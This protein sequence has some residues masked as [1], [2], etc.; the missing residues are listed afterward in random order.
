MARLSALGTRKF[1][2]W[3]RGIEQRRKELRLLSRALPALNELLSAPRQRLDACAARLP[4]ALIANAQLHH[5]QLDRATSRLSKRLLTQRT[6]RC[7]EQTAVFGA[8][9]SRAMLTLLDQRGARLE[10]ADRLLEAFSYR[11]VL[12][13][14]FALV[15]DGEGHPLRRASAVAS[16]ASLDI[17]FADGRV[18]AVAAGEARM[19]P[20][21][22]PRPRRRGGADNEGQGSLFGS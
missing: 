4:R 20:A 3:Q 14:G 19:R 5:R 8:R 1:S 9:A 22:K 15:R 12:E 2:C 21:A 10:R 16:G 11:N 13:R 18:G 17:E 6:E 7:R